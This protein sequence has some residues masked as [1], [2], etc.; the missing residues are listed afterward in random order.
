[1]DV[2]T[3][4][5]FEKR[6]KKQE[7][8]LIDTTPPLQEALKYRYVLY[9]YPVLGKSNSVLPAPGPAHQPWEITSTA[10]LKSPRGRRG[11][12]R[13]ITHYTRPFWRPGADIYKYIYT[14]IYALAQGFYNMNI[15][16]PNQLCQ[17]TARF[18]LNTHFVYNLEYLSSY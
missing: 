6:E 11:L 14:Y 16:K 17:S 12:W 8:A 7:G 10:L 2:L 3:K 4:V 13:P 9:R 15:F 18:D 5:K 1:M